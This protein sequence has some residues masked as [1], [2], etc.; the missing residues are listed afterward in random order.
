VT[1]MMELGRWVRY[2][3]LVVVAAVVVIVVVSMLTRGGGA[4]AAAPA[5]DVEAAVAE[6]VATPTAADV[7]PAVAPVVPLPDDPE[8]RF[9]AMAA[10]G[11][12]FRGTAGSCAAG[13]APTLES[14]SDA[15]TWTSALPDGATQL[16]GLPVDP[17]APVVADA[18]CAAP[19]GWAAPAAQPEN[20]LAVDGDVAAT[21]TEGRVCIGSIAAD[22]EVVC[23][24]RFDPLDPIAIDAAADGR[25]YVWSGDTLT[26]VDRP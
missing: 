20:V 3:L 9:L 2:A 6:P 19:V 25:V 13:I 15:V 17:L 5:A 12:L 4:P 24:E 1:R 11:T 7:S 14:T 26:A 10:D 23:D 8:Q 21:R 18:A 22:S 16:L